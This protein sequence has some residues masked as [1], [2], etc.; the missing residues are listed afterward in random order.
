[1]FCNC[2]FANLVLC[3]LIFFVFMV[4]DRGTMLD[5]VRAKARILS[6]S[7]K[8][9][10]YR[11]PTKR[12]YIK[13]TPAQKAVKK[14]MRQNQAKSLERAIQGSRDVLE[15]EAQKLKAAFPRHSLLWCRTAILQKPRKKTG[16]AGRW[17]AFLSREMVL[18]NSGES[19]RPSSSCE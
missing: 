3:P 15:E 16:T 9:T 1:M 5:R 7:K 10:A 8:H 4:R 12:L 11:R 6:L 18:A 14:A 13:E 2:L 19:F 17:Q